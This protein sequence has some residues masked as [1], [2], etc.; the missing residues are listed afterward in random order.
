MFD[1]PRNADVRPTTTNPVV[2]LGTDEQRVL[3]P[4]RWGLVPVWWQEEKLPKLT[5]NARSE[6][7]ASKPMFRAAYRRNRALVPATAPSGSG[8]R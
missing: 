7:A 1:F 5:F 3:L 2:I 6:T 4:M 8:R